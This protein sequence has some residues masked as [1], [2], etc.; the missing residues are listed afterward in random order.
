MKIIKVVSIVILGIFGVILVAFIIAGLTIPA[1]KSF[2]NT[3]DINKPP[4]RVWQVLIDRDK[5]VEWQPNV[6][7]VDVIDYQNWV[8]YPKDAPEPLKFHLAKDLRPK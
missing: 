2:T 8:E 1:E 4:D 3:V 7:K 6:M 5:F